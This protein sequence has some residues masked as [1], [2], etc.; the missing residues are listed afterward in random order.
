MIKYQKLQLWLLENIICSMLTI[1]A[2]MSPGFDSAEL[3]AFSTEIVCQLSVENAIAKSAAAA[4]ENIDAKHKVTALQN[5][6]V[7][8]I[9]F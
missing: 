9:L 8:T 2:A 5:A 6:I 7:K 4:N 3:T 1:F